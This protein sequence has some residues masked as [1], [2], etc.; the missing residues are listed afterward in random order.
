MC[1]EAPA[2]RAAFWLSFRVRWKAMAGGFASAG[3]L[4]KECLIPA[5]RMITSGMTWVNVTHDRQYRIRQIY[6]RN[7][8]PTFENDI[9]QK[10]RKPFDFLF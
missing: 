7:M 9:T 8:N 3:T 2:G 1:L 6:I 10:K 5:L 4:L